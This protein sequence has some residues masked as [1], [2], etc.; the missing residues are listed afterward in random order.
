MLRR[1]MVS[2]GSTRAAARLGALIGG[3]AAAFAF[4]ATA[5]AHTAYVLNSGGGISVIDTTTNTVADDVIG[6]G[7]PWTGAISPDASRLYVATGAAVPV[8]DTSS[9]LVVGSIGLSV[10]AVA[11]SP[12]GSRAYFTHPYSEGLVVVD[13]ASDDVVSEIPVGPSPHGLAISPDGAYAYVTDYIENN[14]RVVD[15]DA[16]TVEAT[17]PVGDQ[18]LTAAVG[19]DGERVYVG[20]HE[21][22][23]ITVIDAATNDVVGSPIPVG[24]NPFTIAFTPGGERAYVVD[25][26]GATVSVIDTETD[27]VVDT[28]SVGLNPTGI[29]ITP[30]GSRAYVANQ[31]DDTVSV[32]DLVSGTVVNELSVGPFPRAVAITPNQPPDAE[33]SADPLQV[34]PG[35]P[36]AFDASA[37]SDDEGIKSFR[38]D[39][40]DGSSANSADGTSSH[41]Y[42]E[43]GTYE[44]T[45]TVDDGEGCEPLPEFAQL[46]LASP[47]TGQTAHCNGP[48]AVTS[49]PVTVTVIGR[50][51][52]ALSLK[53]PQTSLRRVEARATCENQGCEA[54]AKG[55]LKVK[56]RGKKARLFKL[57]PDERSLAAD[58]RTTLAPRIPARARRA[59]RRAL[60]SGGKVRAQLRISALAAGEQRRVRLRQTRIVR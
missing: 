14:V 3:L 51:A 23:S 40:G 55:R 54:K 24:D 36:V 12:D 44:A 11:I 16:E 34:S 46:G 59:A 7:N 42:T 26:G 29:A 58:K 43:P 49:E 47:F 45:V 35:V 15:L 5:G 27:D 6:L 28:I 37:S 31:G 13:T 1:L 57:K 17:I 48:S 38:F 52:L 9:N 18:P 21:S 32:L 20:N 39:F 4:A 22:D 50:L 33:L 56:P 10:N 19:P 30:D 2:R 60:R 41:T 53:R 25:F 8:I